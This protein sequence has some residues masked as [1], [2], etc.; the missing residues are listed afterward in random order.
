[1]NKTISVNIGGRV[2]NIEE[3]AFDKLN[4]YLNTIRGYFEG[5]ESTEEII[6]D[7]ELRIAELF[8]EA[9]SEQKQV[10]TT[11]D[12]DEV[13]R[14][15]GKPED[16]I[17]EEEPE[18]QRSSKTHSKQGK[19]V[20]RDPDNKVIFGVCG[21]ISAY[22][23]WDPIVLR[24]L[25]VIL[26]LFAFGSGILLYIILTVIIPK[27]ITTADKLRM[28]GEQVNVG[29]ISKTVNESFEGMKEDIKDFGEKNNINRDRFES[30]GNRIGDL[31]TD[32]ANFLGK[33]LRIIA[34]VL[35]RVLGLILFLAGIFGIFF[36][37]ALLFGHESIIAAMSD[38]H[39]IF[40]EQMDAYLSGTF[41]SSFQYVTFFVG[42]VLILFIP[43]LSL[44]LLGI[45]LLFNYRGIP[46]LVAIVF[47]IL[48][49]TGLALL[50]ACGIHLWRD[51]HI[52]T[53]FTEHVPIELPVSDTLYL[54]ISTSSATIYEFNSEFDRNELFFGDDVT[55][56]GPNSTDFMISGKTE[57]TV[58]IQR[59]DSIYGLYITRSAR[60]SNK[61]DAVNNARI[62]KSN[63]TMSNDSLLISPYLILPN[64]AKI[65]DQRIKYVLKIP[66]GKAIHFA[67]NSRAIIYDVPNLSNTLDS[68]MLDRT[69]IMT[70]DGLRCVNCTEEELEV[71][72][73]NRFERERTIEHELSKR[74]QIEL[75]RAERQM[76]RA[77]EMM[78][79]EL[80]KA[81]ERLDEVHREMEDEFEEQFEDR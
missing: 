26:A 46:G 62:A 6:S 20:F 37:F 43:A 40:D 50:A 11:S 34:K 63:Y 69:W 74:A 24:A 29:N 58:D 56:G 17:D 57:F 9:I 52:E 8:M 32:V 25:F 15:M 1:M 67:P 30:A 23:G 41:S 27:A 72:R 53:S 2:F 79:D 33:A 28:R 5:H 12:V 68:R 54:D 48:W 22:L 38:H 4:K 35:G 70:K 81:E 71:E 61:K 78:E 3:S 77:Q 55:F 80:R 39:M 14:I 49:L 31:V 73:E 18:E 44:L 42:W 59:S 64:E 7:I 36:G 13:I 65:R 47:L 10:I 21:G 60:G 19:R 75:E 76:E 66:V 45:R 16:Y 51:F